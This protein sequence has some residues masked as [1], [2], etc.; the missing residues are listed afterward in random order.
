MDQGV[1][2]RKLAAAPA[3]AAAPAPTLGGGIEK[4]WPLALARAA[5]D[6]LDLALTCQGLQVRRLSLAELL[7]LPADRAL[8]ALLEGPR[9]A[10]GLMILGPD[11][12][13]GLI[14]AQTLGRVLQTPA[15][16]RKPTRTDAA[17]VADWVDAVMAA[18]EDALIT[19]DDLIWTDAFRYVSYLDEPR[20]LALMLED[21][22]WKVVTCEVTLAGA[23]TGPLLLALP[24]EGQGRRPE[25]APPAPAPDAPDPALFAAA[26]AEQVLG[27]EAVLQGVLCRVTVPLSALLA[28]RAGDVMPL[29]HAALDRIELAGI[30][31]QA[32][33]VGRLGQQR[34]LRAVR[35]TQIE[36]EARMAPASLVEPQP[37]AAPPLRLAAAG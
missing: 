18:V 36:G 30:D 21:L 20:P 26:L 28:L 4:A 29:P 13:S 25:R 32:Q 9:A 5:R 34:G 23:K 2:R 35:V 27:A 17:M 6:R 8:I 7:D 37:E 1:I 10:T 3:A 15:A 11:L 14:E 22:P 24:A 31:G 33:V 16:P 19:E 12:L